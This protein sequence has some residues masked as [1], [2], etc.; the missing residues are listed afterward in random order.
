MSYLHLT[1]GSNIQ[2]DHVTE[3]GQIDVRCFKGVN[4]GCILHSLIVII[5]NNNTKYNLT[6]CIFIT[7]S[8]TYLLYVYVFLFRSVPSAGLHDLSRWMG[9][10]GYSGYV[11]G[12]SGEI[13]PW[14]LLCTLGLYAGHHW[15]SGCPD[16]LIPGLRPG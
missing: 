3:F 4:K 2:S 5:Y 6:L 9:F 16:T 14:W 1:K 7:D 12:A 15:H 13:F 8:V 10:R 11:R